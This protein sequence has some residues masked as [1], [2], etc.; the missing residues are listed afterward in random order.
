M[1]HKPIRKKKINSAKLPEYEKWFF[2][3]DEDESATTDRE[4]T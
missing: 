4:H 3:S 2:A 1:L